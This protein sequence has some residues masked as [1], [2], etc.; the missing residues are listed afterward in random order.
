MPNQIGAWATG[1]V[2]ELLQV[3]DLLYTLESGP[4]LPIQL[5]KSEPPCY[6]LHNC[7]LPNIPRS[8]KLLILKRDHSQFSSKTL[9]NNGV[10][11]IKSK[12]VRLQL[13]LVP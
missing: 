5:V 1:R 12:F 8:E 6:T 4:R 10:S 13:L 9:T 2:Q 3:E 7:C 11:F